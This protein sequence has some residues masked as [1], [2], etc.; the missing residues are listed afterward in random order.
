MIRTM[1]L[2]VAI[3]AGLAQQ[4]PRRSAGRQAARVLRQARVT[5]LRVT[6]LTKCRGA[7]CQ[8]SRMT[9]TV[10]VVAIAT[11]FRCR[12][13]LPQ[14]RTAHLGMALE[15][16]GCCCRPGE[17]PVGRVAMCIMAPAAVHLAVAQRVRIRFH[18][19]RALL[20]MTVEA[21]LRLCCRGKNRITFNVARVAI[22]TSDRACR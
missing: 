20:L 14:K 7:H 5:V 4:E 22:R 1:H 12:G 13:V 17:Q 2:V 16:G 6:I 3:H 9:G 10:W 15:A 8:H 11:V 21:D 18:G 19:L